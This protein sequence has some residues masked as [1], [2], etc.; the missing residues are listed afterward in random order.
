MNKIAD[1][2]LEERRQKLLENDND[3]DKL[4]FYLRYEMFEDPYDD[5]LMEWFN[6]FLEDRWIY[7]KRDDELKVM[8]L[9]EQIRDKIYDIEESD[10]PDDIKMSKM[11][12][13]LLENIISN[14]TAA[15]GYPNPKDDETI[16]YAELDKRIWWSVL[17]NNMAYRDLEHISWSMY[18]VD[19][20]G[21]EKKDPFDIFQYYIISDS[22]ADYL[23]RCTDEL[24]FY[25]EELDIYVWWVTHIW[26]SWDYVY[27]TIHY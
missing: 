24:V 2:S 9:I 23:E 13:S 22:W 14:Y 19:E 27:L 11:R 1:L 26:T 6:Y 4:L 12:R 17:C 21:R 3:M 8:Q 5:K 18:D 15:V 7:V 16:T 20:F 10:N 25:D